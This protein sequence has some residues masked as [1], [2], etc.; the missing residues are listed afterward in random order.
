MSKLYENTFLYRVR[1][2]LFTIFNNLPDNR[3]LRVKKE[4]NNRD[5]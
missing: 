4:V 5:Y 2:K 3:S 1:D